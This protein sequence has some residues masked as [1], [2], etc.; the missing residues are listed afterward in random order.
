M[1]AQQQDI[2]RIIDSRGPMTSRQLFDVMQDELGY[3]GNASTHDQR[4]GAVEALS[5]ILSKLKASGLLTG[6]MTPK[7]KGR[8]VIMWDTPRYVM[9][10]ATHNAFVT[11]YLDIRPV[12][13]DH[14]ETAFGIMPPTGVNTEDEHEEM[15]SDLAEISQEQPA[16]YVVN[17]D[18]GRRETSELH[19]SINSITITSE[20]D[21]MALWIKDHDHARQ[22]LYMDGTMTIRNKHELT[23]FIGAIELI[24]EA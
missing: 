11:E 12:S 20:G 21:E 18:I 10:E 4:Q 3:Y 19:I 5:K 22:H 14:P 17:H 24:L 2:I 15:A 1:N 7:E 9:T 13:P 6:D 8:P 23:Q 16:D